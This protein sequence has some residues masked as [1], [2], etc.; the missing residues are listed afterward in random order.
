[1][2]FENDARLV[3]LSRVMFTSFILNASAIVQT[4]RFIKQMNVR[5]VAMSNAIGLTAGAVVG[6]YMAV[7]GWG[8]WA[9]VWQTIVNAAVKSLILWGVSRWVPM[10]RMSWQSLR[11][12]MSVGMGM[13]FTSFLNTLFL[14][15]YSFFIGYRVGLTSLG[16][17]TQSDKWSKMGIASL[18][19]I[20]TSTFLPVLSK[21]Q[22]DA[23]RYANMVRK[24]NRFTAYILFPA[25]LG[26]TVIAT[27]TFHALFGTKWDPS[28]LLFQ[29]LLIRGI[30]TVLTG[31]YSN[32]LLSLGRSREIVWMEVLRD[33]AALIALFIT[34]PYM[35]LTYADNPVY[36]LSILLWGQLI[37]SVIA[38]LGTLIC[39]AAKT[40]ISAFAF[41][42]DCLPYLAISLLMV[43]AIA[44]MQNYISNCWISLVSSVA[45]GAAMYFAINLCLKSLVSTKKS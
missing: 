9:I 33:G 42:A 45:L 40:H 29:L 2:W 38:W 7:T 4:N 10:M 18:S 26:L 1:M 6:I 27:P 19:Q 17:Y 39:V 32:Y 21:V 24:M 30:F 14:N 13:M 25:M 22:D 28:I 41:I 44:L 3:P 15:I 23:A 12:F 5:P 16:Y 8:A 43:G 31:L 37:A 20:L 34:L 35:G 11:S 36:G